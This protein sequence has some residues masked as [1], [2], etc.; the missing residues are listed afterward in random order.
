MDNQFLLAI[1]SSTTDSEKI[2]MLI[3]YLQDLA[4]VV[5]DMKNDIAVLKSRIGEG[6]KASENASDLVYVNEMIGIYG[7]TLESISGHLAN[8]DSHLQS[9]DSHLESIGKSLEAHTRHLE[10]H[11]NQLDMLL[12]K[13]K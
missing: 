9:H 10:A 1:S 5:G 13:N 3:K 2:R 4:A 6:G 11:D 8:H 12:G 7:R